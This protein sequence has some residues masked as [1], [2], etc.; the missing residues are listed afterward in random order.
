MISLTQHLE[1]QRQ[2]AQVEV[3]RDPAVGDV[4]IH[5]INTMQALNRPH[6]R[7]TTEYCQWMWS[8]LTTGAPVEQ[9]NPTMDYFIK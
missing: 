4:R 5:Y 2:K 8:Q 9:F 3:F 1:D 7:V 6:S